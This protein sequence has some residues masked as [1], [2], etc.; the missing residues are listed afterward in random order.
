M[1][2]EV[3]DEKALSREVAEARKEAVTRAARKEKARRGSNDQQEK[4]L[5]EIKSKDIRSK[6]R[7]LFLEKN[8]KRNRK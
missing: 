7:P 6:P 5:D 4:K 2:S 8:R 3:R 1:E